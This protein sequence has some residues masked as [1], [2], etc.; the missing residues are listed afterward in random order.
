MFCSAFCMSIAWKHHLFKWPTVQKNI[1]TTHI[2]YDEIMGLHHRSPALLQQQQS[3]TSSN[4]FNIW[5]SC[6]SAWIKLSYHVFKPW[7]ECP[8]EGQREERTDQ[9]KTEVLHMHVVSSYIRGKKWEQRERTPH[10][11]KKK[12]REKKVSDF[13]NLWCRGGRS[14]AKVALFVSAEHKLP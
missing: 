13:P 3:M 9:K 14:D 1:Q 6:G 2:R 11:S 5:R 4:S 8:S 12:G 10:K 7:P